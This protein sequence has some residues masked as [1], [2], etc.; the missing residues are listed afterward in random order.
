MDKGTKIFCIG[1]NKTGTTSLHSAFE[2]LG[3]RSVHFEDR[4]G[5][6]IQDIIRSNHEQGLPI[7]RG[8]E[9][10]DAY[11]DWIT[12]EPEAVFPKFDAEYPGSK[13][14]LHTR[15]M[16]GWLRSR[17]KHVKRNQ[18]EFAETKDPK[19]TWLEIDLVGWEAHYKAYHKAV[20]EHFKGR[21]MDLLELD[22]T[23]GDGWEL[24]C[25]FLGVKAPNV[26]FPVANVAPPANPPVGSVPEK[27][28]WKKLFR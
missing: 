23:Q 14:I 25:P 28:L 9:D 11:S 18:K 17:E 26:P 5:R 13:F 16:A 1:L 10:F 6:N 27:S 15:D 19:I 12:D 24:L 20:R 7:L 2:L 4:D 3:Y 8:I 22:V 21:E